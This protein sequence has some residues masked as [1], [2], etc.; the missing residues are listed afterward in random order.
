MIN[1]FSMTLQ[2]TIQ[3]DIITA[4]KAKDADTLSTLRNL[5]SAIK[6]EM[7]DHKG[8]FTDSDVEKIVARQIKQL[9]DAITDFSAGGRT[10]LVEQNEREIGIIKR[11]L[12]AQMADD[13]LSRIVTET[14]AE[15]GMNTKADMGKLMG[16]VMAK[17]QGK[18]D[19]NRVKEAVAEKLV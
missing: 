16:A 6:N 7:I 10:D 12:P 9:K 3:Q 2:E 5:S 8:D 15:T 13:E 4:M 18:A 11:Y 14:I 1:K 19:G 17:V